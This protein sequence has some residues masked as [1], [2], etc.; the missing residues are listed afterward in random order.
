MGGKACAPPAFCTA[1]KCS[2]ASQSTTSKS[3]L[4]RTGGPEAAALL[5]RKPRLSPYSDA[6][7]P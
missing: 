3:S 7:A 4:E 6:E 5:R 1:R 2:P